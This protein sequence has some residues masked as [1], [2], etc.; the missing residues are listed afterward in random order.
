L[1]LKV[2]S[3]WGHEDRV[4]KAVK[5]RY[6][7]IPAL[8]IMVKDHKSVPLADL[9]VRPVCRSSQSPNGIL[10]DLL[11]DFLKVLADEIVDREGTEIRSTEEMCNMIENVNS[12]LDERE[13]G[14]TED[15]ISQ[16]KEIVVGSKDAKALYPSLDADQAARIIEEQVKESMMDVEVDVPALMMHM[17]ATH[18]VKEIED[19]NLQDVCPTRRFNKGSRPGISSDSV[20]GTVKE[21][22]ESDKWVDP[23]RIPSKEEV[24]ST[25]AAVIA[26]TV[27]T[28]M[29]NHVYTTGG[30]IYKQSKGGS[31]GLRA[32]GE[33][34]RLVCLKFDQL[35]REGTKR[36]G[37]IQL[38]YGRYVDDSNSAYEAVDPG[39]R[40]EDGVIV[41]K[42]ELVEIDK[43]SPADRRT[44]ELVQGIAN[45]IF[46]NLQWTFDVPSNYDC[47]RM[48]V[49][50]LQVGIL[51]RRITYEFYQKDVSTRYTIPA[52]SAHSWSIKRSTLTQEGVRRL[53]NTSPDTNP[54]VR[55]RVMEMWD[56]KMRISGYDARFRRTVVKAAV[57]IY[58]DKLKRAETGQVPLYRSRS[59]H[60][61]ERDR[62][63][64]MKISNWYKS[65][66]PVE[67]MAPL[68]LNPT[69]DGQ[70][71]KDVD[72]IVGQFADTH[73]MKI[74]VM[75][76]GGR[77]SGADVCSDPFGDKICKRQNCMICTKEGTKGGCRG[78]G[79]GY[80]NTCLS[81]PHEKGQENEMARYYGE[82]GKSNYE[83]GLSHQRDLRN[84]VEDSALWKHCQLVH[85]SVKVDFKMETTGTF[86]SCEE[87]QI[88]EGSRVKLSGVKYVLNSKSEWHQPPIIRVVAV[89]GN[90][91]EFQGD[92]GRQG[93]QSGRGAAG[94][95]GRGV[96]RG[97]AR[98]T[99]GRRAAANP[100]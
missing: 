25:L 100:V 84:E 31:I 18:S 13:E 59:W 17:A 37:L 38:M 80:V 26:N 93:R 71:R 52:R 36:A 48:P 72:K 60:K 19:R 40:I 41:V 44:F 81:C 33:I 2:G 89:S 78:Q 35:L 11:S 10:S 55:R 32:T 87:R 82:T 49:L 88:D 70:L 57:G 66:G 20:T 85:N 24:K 75:E 9:P 42:E 47:K 61:E 73:M 98:R 77:K 15:E 22:D 12:K 86:E 30:L 74:K 39:S 58:R 3:H 53:L 51:N 63:K 21:R 50:D 34:S 90:T 69:A 99:A 45:G 67:T 7:K 83:R 1:V 46:A 29:S 97:R 76:R 94:N 4:Q 68:I 62:E 54:D 43:Q 14:L 92:T 96:D 8:D 16:L 65:E 27:K 28:V 91:Q 23:V 79:M 64:A 6:T 95:R 56:S 5:A